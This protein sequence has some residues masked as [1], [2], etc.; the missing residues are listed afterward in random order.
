MLSDIW[1]ISFQ[2]RKWGYGKLAI[3]FFLALP[4]KV[5]EKARIICFG[6]N[7][8]KLYFV[9]QMRGFQSHAF[10]FIGA[11]AHPQKT[12]KNR[13][14]VGGKIKNLSVNKTCLSVG[15]NSSG[16]MQQRQIGILKLFI[17]DQ[18]LPKAIEP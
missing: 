8:C 1:R 4:I 16:H 7:G 15:D 10:G 9:F 18:Y 17:T 5:T 11:V 3:I 12:S 14:L 13:M 2:F 6:V